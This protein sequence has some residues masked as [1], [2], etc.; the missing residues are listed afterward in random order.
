VNIFKIIGKFLS[1]LIIATWSAFD[2]RDFF[3]FGGWG[4]L[5]YGLYLFQGQ[6]L[7]FIT[8]GP[9]LMAIGYLMRGKR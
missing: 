9:L 4:M 8:C 7:A 2:I 6:W 1:S 3:V 5:G